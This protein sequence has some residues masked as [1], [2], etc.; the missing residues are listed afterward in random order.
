[1]WYFLSL[2]ITQLVSGYFSE[3]FDPCVAVYSVH[4]WQE[5]KTEAS[6]FTI[7]VT[8]LEI[9]AIIF[10]ETLQPKPF[11]IQAEKAE[12]KTTT[13][14]HELQLLR[15]IFDQNSLFFSLIDLIKYFNMSL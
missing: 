9:L 1:M 7:L 12:N 11:Q 2:P 8:A 5:G 3:G 14:I 13:G 10:L 4:L 6:Y 15:L